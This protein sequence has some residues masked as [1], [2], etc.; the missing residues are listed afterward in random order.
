MRIKT[1]YC[2]KKNHRRK[3]Q[4]KIRKMIFEINNLNSII[5]EKAKN[6]CIKI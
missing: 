5:E 3:S 6:S 1:Y 4:R 2:D